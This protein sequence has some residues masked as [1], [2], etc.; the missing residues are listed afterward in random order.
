[1]NR[2]DRLLGILMQLQRHKQRRAEDLASTFEVS[3]RTIYRD[4]QALCETGVPVIAMTGQGY[5]LPEEFFLPPLNFTLEEAFMLILGTDFIAQSFD[6]HYADIAQSATEKIQM[7]L[8]DPYSDEIAY[9]KKNIAIY[10]SES[11]DENRTF[12]LKQLRQ[13]IMQKRSVQIAYTKRFQTDLESQSTLREIDPYRLAQYN[14]IWFLQA[15]CHLREEI[16]I[17]RLSRIDDLRILPLSFER[18][19]NLTQEWVRPDSVR[20]LTI[21][22]LACWEVAR[23]IQ[24]SPSFFTESMEEMPDG[25]LIT[26]KVEHEREVMQWLLSY[27]AS[28]KIL[29]PAHLRQTMIEEARA[30][31][32]QYEKVKIPY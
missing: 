1:M 10:A 7:V 4:I 31:L 12:K 27:G 21:K 28:I 6:S 9:L 3:V 30:V 14:N 13:A 22:V 15:Y 26:L 19:Q 29:E 32:E 18:P 25:L 17:F 11:S 24:E 16:R 5:S 2:S 23:W 8:P 20:N